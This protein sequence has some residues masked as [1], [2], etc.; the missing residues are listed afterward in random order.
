MSTT[1]EVVCGGSFPQRPATGERMEGPTP[2]FQ[3]EFLAKVQRLLSEGSFVASYKFALLLSLADLAVELGDDTNQ[4]LTLTSAQLAEKF[5]QLYWRQAAPYLA[6]RSPSGSVLVQ[7]TG[8]QAAIINAI[9]L[10]R[11]QSP[12]L[13][14]FRHTR[15]WSRLVKRVATVIE[16]MPLW[17][18]Q[19]VGNGTLEFLY[20]NLGTG[21]V[22][23]LKAG[24]AACLRR[25][26]GL[27][28]DLVRGSWVRYVRRFNEGALGE[29]ND[30]HDFLFGS[31][32][33]ALQ[34]VAPI[35]HELQRGECFYCGKPVG[36]GS[37]HVDHFIPWSRYPVDLGHNFVL[38]HDRPCNLGKSDRL[39]SGEHLH[40]WVE[41]N[42]RHEGLLLG[43]FDRRGITHD[44]PTSIQIAKWAY[45]QVA[46]TQGLVWVAGTQLAPLGSEWKTQ[47]QG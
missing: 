16:V 26:H 5:I 24:V 31:E 36:T 9:Q 11:A 15:E 2:E 13:S 4:T 27:L 10:A 22:I 1:Q 40:R 18:L 39:A 43:E 21:S 35:L 34:E 46:S 8:K 25:F 28:G 12:L 19:T 45:S 14:E 44:L 30:L 3:V 6:L 32:R 20:D 29:T 33:K 23:T 37:T 42:R 38:A 17:K 7:N 47:L 41:R